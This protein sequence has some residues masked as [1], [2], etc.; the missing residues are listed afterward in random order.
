VEKKI[1][2]KQGGQIQGKGKMR[3]YEKAH[4]V[5]EG[6]VEQVSGVQVADGGDEETIFVGRD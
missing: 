3:K 6:G 1:N 5:A 2:R 4:E